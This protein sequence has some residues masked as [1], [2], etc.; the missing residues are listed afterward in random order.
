MNNTPRQSLRACVNAQCKSC[1]YDPLSA[2]TWREQVAACSN[3]GCPLFNVRPVPRDCT[4]GGGTC[5]A[6]VAAVCLKLERRMDRRSRELGLE[7]AA[8]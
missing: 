6:A 1:I 5:P 2:G 8:A 3:G 4:K 7:V